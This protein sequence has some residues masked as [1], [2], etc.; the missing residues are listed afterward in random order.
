MVHGLRL[1]RRLTVCLCACEG[2]GWARAFSW[3]GEERGRKESG[4]CRCQLS[5][6]GTND[7]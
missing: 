6:F 5:L 2:F 1:S 4:L 3:L 7:R